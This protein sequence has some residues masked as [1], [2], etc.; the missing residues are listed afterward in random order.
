MD[1][2]KVLWKE[3]QLM[4]DRNNK[5]DSDQVIGSGSQTKVNGSTKTR[6]SGSNGSKISSRQ[7]EHSI[8]KLVETLEATAG[9]NLI[10]GRSKGYKRVYFCCLGKRQFA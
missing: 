10:P 7:S 6:P 8:A 1:A 2:I 5:S 3:V 4:D 9:I